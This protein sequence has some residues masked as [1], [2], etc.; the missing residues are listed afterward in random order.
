MMAPV[1]NSVN[2]SAGQENT[3]CENTGCEN[4]GQETLCL[5]VWSGP[6]NI[7]TA[8]MYS[9]A[10]R[11]DTQVIDEPFYG[12]YLV[13]SPAREYHPG[14][15]ETIASMETD[16]QV[17]L[18]QILGQWKLPVLFLKNMTHHLVELD[19]SFVDKLC[20][21]ILVRD[22]VEM[23]PSYAKEVEQPTLHDTGYDTL[24]QLV[25]YLEERGHPA[26]PVL[27]SK[28]VLLDPATVLSK[29]CDQVGIDFDDA[30]LS[31]QAGARPEDGAWAKYWYSSV[32]KSTGFQKYRPKHEPFPTHLEPLLAECLPY[33]ERLE[34]LAI[35]A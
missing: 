2:K 32:H 34:K 9:F 26:P 27:D 15:E 10:Q 29:L 33:Y 28:E 24:V 20:N 12:Y 18:D 1:N 19:W 22:P 23:L 30:M 16:A 6:R 5:S 14:A 21:V 11:A 8:L 25:D 4:T 3:G 17:V 13:N 31:W 35:R 7:S